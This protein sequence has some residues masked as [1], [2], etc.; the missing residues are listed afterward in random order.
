MNRAGHACVGEANRGDPLLL[1]GADYW[2]T[3]ALR[4]AGMSRCR[5][6]F[7]ETLGTFRSELTLRCL[8]PGWELM[9]GSV[10]VGWMWSFLRTCIIVVVIVATFVGCTVPFVSLIED[11]LTE[12]YVSKQF[13]A[14]ST[15]AA[16]VIADLVSDGDVS[17]SVRRLPLL[18]ERRR[19]QIWS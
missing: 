16:F 14:R 7:F 19:E 5:G 13:P 12:V 9:E 10:F 15:Q 8:F 4:Y 18:V 1:I 17:M 2:T 3:R 6:V 11:V